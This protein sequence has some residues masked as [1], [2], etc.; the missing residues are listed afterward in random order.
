[1]TVGQTGSPFLH[2]LSRRALPKRSF[3]QKV[4]RPSSTAPS[5]SGSAM[6]DAEGGQI[7]K[8]NLPTI[9]SGRIHAQHAHEEEA[10]AVGQTDRPSVIHPRQLLKQV[11]GTH[12][13]TSISCT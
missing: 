7:D 6:S 5:F 2:P 3:G 13:F 1:M 8:G 11:T 12:D 9:A 4:S 10:A